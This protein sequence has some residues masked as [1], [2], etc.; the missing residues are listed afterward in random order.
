MK[1]NGAFNIYIVQINNNGVLNFNTPTT[2]YR[3]QPFP[4]SGNIYIAPFWTDIDTRGCPEI[5]N[6]VYNREFKESDSNRYHVFENISKIVE[7]SSVFQALSG[8]CQVPFRTTWAFAVTWRE[9][10]YHGVDCDKVCTVHNLNVFCISD[11]VN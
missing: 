4:I 2:A 3:P 10:K 1:L 9:V 7:S 6:T 11:S 5:D 8:H